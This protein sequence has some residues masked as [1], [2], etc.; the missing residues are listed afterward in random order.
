M[1]RLV[2]QKNGGTLRV[3][4]KGDKLNGSGRQKK[5]IS[6][7]VQQGYNK[8]QIEEVYLLMMTFTVDQLKTVFNNP[9]ATILE[10]IVCAALSKSVGRGTLEQVEIMLSRVYHKPLTTIAGKDGESLMIA[11]TINVVNIEAAKA[12]NKI[13]KT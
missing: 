13:S 9:K 3:L 11:P 1:A 5:M 8:R 7:I 6:E 2:K 12:L 10:K 4:E